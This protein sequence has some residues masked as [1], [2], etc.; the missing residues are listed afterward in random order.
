ME[1]LC[2]S[3][4]EHNF[5]MCNME[6][7]KGMNRKK[8]SHMGN[9]GWD[10]NFAPCHRP[11]I[12]PDICWESLVWRAQKLSKITWDVK[13]SWKPVILPD[14]LHQLQSQKEKEKCSL[15]KDLDSRPLSRHDWSFY[16]ISYPSGN[17]WVD[18]ARSGYT[19]CLKWSCSNCLGC[20][21]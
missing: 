11:V 10:P 2:P 21:D 6:P 18:R 4:K 20:Y 8:V 14:T 5:T 13:K 17:T 15:K 1:E 16:P 12:R 3:P 9:L 7:V 19:F